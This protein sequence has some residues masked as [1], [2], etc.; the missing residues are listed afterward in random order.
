[1]R[2]SCDLLIRGITYKLRERAYGGLP[3]ATAR[4]LE[5]A[6]ADEPSGDAAKP[7][8]LITLRPGTRLVREW[9]GVTHNVLIHADWIE[10]CGQRYPSLLRGRAKDHWRPLVGAAVP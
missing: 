10:W 5:Q 7:V 9:H 1:M 2:L 3:L 4:K 6:A 8:P